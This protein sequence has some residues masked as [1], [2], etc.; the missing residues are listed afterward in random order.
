MI[1]K[2]IIFLVFMLIAL[3]FIVIGQLGFDLETETT[4][5][6]AGGI[7]GLGLMYAIFSD[8]KLKSP[9]KKT[10]Q[11]K[12]EKEK[13][14]EKEKEPVTK[15]KEPWYMRI[16]F[17]IFGLAIMA[18]LGVLFVNALLSFNEMTKKRSAQKQTTKKTP[19]QNP[20]IELSPGQTKSFFKVKKGDKFYLEYNKE[21]YTRIRNSPET[22]FTLRNP[23]LSGNFYADQNG[24]LE[25]RAKHPKTKVS[26]YLSR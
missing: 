13:E 26:A 14:E 12:K 15:E 3:V 19:T 9:K 25:V 18:A 22:E 2:I 8:L 1:K 16:L 4:L 11:Q 6:I 10:N 20:A 24:T 21:L 17:G 7:A 5:M 23:H